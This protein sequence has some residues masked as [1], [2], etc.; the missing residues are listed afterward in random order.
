MGLDL[1]FKTV[2]L[3]MFLN[4]AAIPNNPYDRMIELSFQGELISASRV[5]E[6]TNGIEYFGE[7]VYLKSPR[8]KGALVEFEHF[9]RTAQSI[10]TQSMRAIYQVVGYE[11]LFKDYF[12]D[13]KSLLWLGYTGRYNDVEYRLSY[14][15]DFDGFEKSEIAVGYKLLLGN[16][17]FIKPTFENSRIGDLKYWQLKVSFEYDLKLK[18]VEKSK[19]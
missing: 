5:W 12:E 19:N 10:N 1:F 6:R 15:T 3:G 8:L 2:A 4:S 14:S 7:R 9:K 18:E 17:L 11:A 13:P 16:N